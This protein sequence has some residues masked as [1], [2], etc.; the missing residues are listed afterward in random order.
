MKLLLAIVN[1]DDADVVAAALT[2]EHF[3]VT[4]LATTGGFLKVANTTFLIGTE[5]ERVDLA[6]SIIQRH[7]Q[8]RT[9]PYPITAPFGRTP[10]GGEEG[11]TVTVGG[12]T[13][14][15]FNMEGME[16]Y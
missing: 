7:S 4:S 14:M 3:S 15:V 5:E 11:D 2:K 10:V 13:V 9:Y 16:K 6:K 12:A 1:S 8:T